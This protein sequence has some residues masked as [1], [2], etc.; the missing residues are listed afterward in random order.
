MILVPW[1]RTLAGPSEIYSCWPHSSGECCTQDTNEMLKL[2]RVKHLRISQ[3]CCLPRKFSR[4]L[5]RGSTG[6]RSGQS[7]KFFSTKCY[8]FTNSF[9]PAK[10]SGYTEF[11]KVGDTTQCR[12]LMAVIINSLRWDLNPGQSV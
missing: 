4:E 10:V 3:H 6:M 5:M 9:S 8:I 1:K 2:S 11:S 7:T 12:L